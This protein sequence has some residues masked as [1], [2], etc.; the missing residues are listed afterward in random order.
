MIRISAAMRF[1]VISHRRAAGEIVCDWK[2]PGSDSGECVTPECCCYLDER[3]MHALFLMHVTS[4][5]CATDEKIIISRI[6][7]GR[8]LFV[9]LLAV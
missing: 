3:Q 1:T 8:V 4:G 5:R 6:G 7:D 2:T 9:P